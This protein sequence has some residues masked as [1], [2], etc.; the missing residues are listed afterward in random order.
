MEDVVFKKK[1]AGRQER[2]ISKAL[3]KLGD[4]YFSWLG[5]GEDLDDEKEYA[6]LNETWKKLRLHIRWS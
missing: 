6:R 3:Q 5:S 2:K 1:I 4:E